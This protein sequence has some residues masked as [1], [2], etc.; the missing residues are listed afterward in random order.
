MHWQSLNPAVSPMDCFPTGAEY[1]HLFN[2]NDTVK[3][4]RQ[5]H[6]L[7]LGLDFAL[8]EI[9]FFFKALMA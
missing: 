5:H 9:I 8:D 3:T 7:D 1:S 6:Y 2:D 4:T